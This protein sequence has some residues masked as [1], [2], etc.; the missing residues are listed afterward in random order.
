LNWKNAISIG[1]GLDAMPNF[2][3]IWELELVKWYNYRGHVTA[4]LHDSF[5]AYQKGVQKNQVC[6]KR[7]IAFKDIFQSSMSLK[8]PTV[9]KMII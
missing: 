5:F 1:I 4:L 7:L 8:K 9:E 6:F 3:N 2:L